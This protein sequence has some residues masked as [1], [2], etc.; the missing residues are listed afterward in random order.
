MRMHA[1]R[2]LIIGS[3]RSPTGDDVVDQQKPNEM[4]GFDEES[5]LCGRHRPGGQP[6][7]VR[8]DGG[9]DREGEAGRDVAGAAERGGVV[10]HQRQILLL[11]SNEK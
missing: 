1:L 2:M 9:G 10:A 5:R 11:V 3:D 7:D 8:A 6:D 4:V